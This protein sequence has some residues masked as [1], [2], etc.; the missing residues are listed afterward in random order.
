MAMFSLLQEARRPLGLLAQVYLIQAR[1]NRISTQTEYFNFS[2]CMFVHDAIWASLG[3]CVFLWLVNGGSIQA[4]ETKSQIADLCSQ[5]IVRYSLN[6]VFGSYTQ[7][8]ILCAYMLC[9][10]NEVILPGSS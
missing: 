6:D 10:L 7:P 3:R 8:H 2:D 4:H 9:T 5:S 1:N